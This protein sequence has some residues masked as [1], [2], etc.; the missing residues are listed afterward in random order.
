MIGLTWAPIAEGE[1][2]YFVREDAFSR[3]SC[4]RH[5][6]TQVTT[7]EIGYYKAMFSLG[8][9]MGTTVADFSSIIKDCAAAEADVLEGIPVGALRFLLVNRTR[10]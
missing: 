1:R 6:V 5:C 3:A 8:S 10:Y 7:N 2:E 9:D 4:A